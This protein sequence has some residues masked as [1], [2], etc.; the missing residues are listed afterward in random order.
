MGGWAT[1]ACVPGTVQALRDL[2]PCGLL[3]VATESPCIFPIQSLE[4]LPCQAVRGPL[5][6]WLP[7]SVVLFPL[8]STLIPVSPVLSSFTFS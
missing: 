8:L 5:Y 6:L 1:M 7:L 3:V 2:P 4:L